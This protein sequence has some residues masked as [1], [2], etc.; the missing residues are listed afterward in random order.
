MLAVVPYL[1]LTMANGSPHR[2]VPLRLGLFGFFLLTRRRADAPIDQCLYGPIALFGGW[3]TSAAHL[4]GAC[5]TTV[6]VG[7]LVFHL[8]S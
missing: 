3:L 2:F 5:G 7:V 8:S 6:S 1:Q 4:T